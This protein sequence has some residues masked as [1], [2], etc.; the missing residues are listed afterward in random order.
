MS[1]S[2]FKVV[3]IENIHVHRGTENLMC[4]TI[5]KEYTVK[6]TDEFTYYVEDSNDGGG[7]YSKKYFITI[8]EIRDIKIDSILI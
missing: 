3:C 5:G 6:E 4:L 1:T 8:E 2:L 7:L